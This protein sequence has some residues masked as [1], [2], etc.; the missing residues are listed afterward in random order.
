MCRLVELMDHRRKLDVAVRVAAIRPVG[1]FLLT[2]GTIHHSRTC[3]GGEAFP[4]EDGQ[5][6]PVRVPAC[7][8]V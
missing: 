3:A 1:L 7:A 6:L 5:A 2:S 8:C 4:R